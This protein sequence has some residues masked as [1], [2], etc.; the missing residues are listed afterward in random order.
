MTD[1]R[2]HFECLHLTAPRVGPL[3]RA[4]LTDGGVKCLLAVQAVGRSV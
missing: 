4:L 2:P 1:P 3:D